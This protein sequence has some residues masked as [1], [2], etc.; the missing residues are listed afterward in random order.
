MSNIYE[1]A[2]M[3]SG[4][5][6]GKAQK[7]AKKA[8][9]TLKKVDR[10]KDVVDKIN[11]GIQEALGKGKKG[12]WMNIGGSLLGLILAAAVPGGGAFANTLI[13]RLTQAAIVGATSAGAE[14]LRQKKYD[15]VEEIE[16]L[17]N[18]YGHL[19]EGQQLGQI[20]AD[21]K[22]QRDSKLMTDFWTSAA[23]SAVI[24]GGKEAVSAKGFDNIIKATADVTKDQAVDILDI[25][26]TLGGE[27]EIA[28]EAIRKAATQDAIKTGVVAG[29][30]VVDKESTV[31]DFLLQ[32]DI[33]D[34]DWLK[35]YLPKDGSK[36]IQNIIDEP[37]SKIDRGESFIPKEAFTDIAIAPIQDETGRAVLGG[38]TPMIDDMVGGYMPEFGNK[39]MSPNEVSKQ[40]DA[41]NPW[42]I[43]K[44]SADINADA[45][46]Q[47][48]DNSSS[49][50]EDLTAQDGPSIDMGGGLSLPTTD[51]SSRSL[52]LNLT[53]DPDYNVFGIPGND[54]LSKLDWSGAGGQTALGATRVLLPS[55]ISQLYEPDAYWSPYRQPR[56]ADYNP[57]NYGGY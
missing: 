35:K 51:A 49:I 46:R 25:I 8:G 28:K 45:I 16:E 32:A 48:L 2:K 13:R 3:Q 5:V 42:D 55:L 26:T 23:L 4:D 41:I 53:I 9:A 52:G 43:N 44:Y 19:E 31:G 17:Q 33:R 54:K 20:A 36:T 10:K 7:K 30:D 6:Y 12:G 29:K 15:S 24:P 56:F 18:M 22:Q 38:G 1:I 40:I 39:A 14:K 11:K 21:V 37:L 57:Y 50:F 27:D 34:S 47:N